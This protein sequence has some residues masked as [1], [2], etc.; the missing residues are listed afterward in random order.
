MDIELQTRVFS[1]S[2]YSENK[3]WCLKAIFK[4]I[5]ENN[6]EFHL[7]SLKEKHNHEIW[8]SFDSIHFQ[9]EFVNSYSLSVNRARRI[10]HELIDKH[11][12]KAPDYESL[13]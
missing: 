5:N 13:T 6:K 1:V 2:Y 9:H 3:L 12:F 8:I 7:Y 10:W 4:L 11:D